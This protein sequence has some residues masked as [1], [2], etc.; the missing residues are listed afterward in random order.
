MSAALARKPVFQ[1]EHLSPIPDPACGSASPEW[2]AAAP[3]HLARLLDVVRQVKRRNLSELAMINLAEPHLRGLLDAS[4][5]RREKSYRT[6]AGDVVRP[7]ITITN[8]PFGPRLVEVKRPHISPSMVIRN[9][10]G[11]GMVGSRC[12]SGGAQALSYLRTIPGAESVMFWNGPLL[13]MLRRSDRELTAY[14]CPLRQMA[15]AGPE[16]WAAFHEVF[17][18]P[19][20]EDLSPAADRFFTERKRDH[21]DS[22]VTESTIVWQRTMKGRG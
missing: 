4:S 15:G 21:W 3:G 13:V 10:R 16:A 20:T 19:G 11:D 6:I 9:P 12:A 5:W 7:D 8:P 17:C 22:G 2:L 1:P 18:R 14:L